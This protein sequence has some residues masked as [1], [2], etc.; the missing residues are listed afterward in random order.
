[1]SLKQRGDESRDDSMFVFQLRCELSQVCVYKCSTRIF[2]CIRICTSIMYVCMHGCINNYVCM[3]SM[4]AVC[5]RACVCVHVCV[6]VCVSVCVRVCVHVC[7]CVYVCLCAPYLRKF[8]LQII[9]LYTYINL[10]NFSIFLALLY[11]GCLSLT[12]Q[13]NPAV[14]TYLCS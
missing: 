1:M 7:V 6:C 11:R 12:H 8:S 13:H 5:V 3:Y 4:C 10:K 14:P 9:H 2:M